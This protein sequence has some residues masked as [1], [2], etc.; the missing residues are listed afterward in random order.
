[1]TKTIKTL[2]VVAVALAVVAAP[3]G[4]NGAFLAKQDA[5][6]KHGADNAP[7]DNGG[8]RGGNSGGGN[9]GGSG[10]GGADDGAGHK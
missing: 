1:M 9:G 4:F 6:A 10:R 2:A 8:G 5:Q 7:G 3:V